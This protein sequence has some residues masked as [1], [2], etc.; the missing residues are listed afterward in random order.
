[1]RSIIAC[2]FVFIASANLFA[3]DRGRDEFDF[4]FEVPRTK[5]PSYEVDYIDFNE[6]A[7][8][9]F[10]ARLE[11][12]RR[13]GSEISLLHNAIR[14][15]ADRCDSAGLTAYA[16]ELRDKIEKVPEIRVLV[17]S[18]VEVLNEL[19][20]DQLAKIIFDMATAEKDQTRKGYLD[21][22]VYLLQKAG[23]LYQRIGNSK[24]QACLLQQ[25]YCEGNLTDCKVAAARVLR[26]STCAL[27]GA[28]ILSW[29]PAV[30]VAS[31]RWS[32]ARIEN[33]KGV[34]DLD[35]E[36]CH[37]WLYAMRPI[38]IEVSG[39]KWVDENYSSPESRT[40]IWLAV[41]R[42]MRCRSLNYIGD[43]G[44]LTSTECTAAIN[45]GANYRKADL[46]ALHISMHK[47]DIACCGP[48]PTLSPQSAPQIILEIPSSGCGC[49][50]P[51]PIRRVLPSW[52]R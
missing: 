45:E 4:R 33:L 48:A 44:P 51:A 42:T 12:M 49:G 16:T 35:M 7:K 25:M 36:A 15:A 18:E 10:D 21:S 13:G 50:G 9:I 26:D 43:M 2:L 3:D 40:G 5:I 28:D 30:R 31:Q 11:V 22:A 24:A 20:F 41:T 6:K 17:E 38:F 27:H 37:R 29:Y 32:Q 8:V 39:Q 46:K 23:K 1:M 47:M 14:R 52:C 34:N 19:Y